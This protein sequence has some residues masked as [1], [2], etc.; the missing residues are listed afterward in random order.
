MA[1]LRINAHVVRGDKPDNDAVEK[2]R[3]ELLALCERHGLWFVDG[4]HQ[5]LVSKERDTRPVEL[6]S[7]EA[8]VVKTLSPGDVCK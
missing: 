5:L 4:Y 1:F 7:G 8:R 2:F 3:A 6:L